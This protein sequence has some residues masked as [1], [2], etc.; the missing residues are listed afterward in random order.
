MTN[1]ILTWEI[2]PL[3]KKET[4][5]KVHFKCMGS[6]SWICHFLFILLCEWFSIL[7]APSRN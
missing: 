1:E 4:S 3:E 5:Q 2:T 7:D 6:F